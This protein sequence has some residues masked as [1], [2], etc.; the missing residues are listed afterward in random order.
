MPGRSPEWAGGGTSAMYVLCVGMYR[1]CSTWQYGVVGQL[2]EREL[3]VRQ[4]LVGRG[5]VLA[6]VPVAAR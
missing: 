2:L 3:V 5:L 4:F 1:A 6:K